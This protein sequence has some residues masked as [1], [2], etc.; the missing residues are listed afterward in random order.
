M[1]RKYSPPP[2]S[3][4]SDEK[5][6]P[7]PGKTLK[8]AV[9]IVLATGEE[10]YGHLT[11]SSHQTIDDLF[12]GPGAFLSLDIGEGSTVLLNKAQIQSAEV[13]RVPERNQL[14]RR[15]SQIGNFNA[16][17]SLNLEPGATGAAIKTAYHAM[18]RRYHPDRFSGKDVPPEILTYANAMLQRINLAYKLLSPSTPT[19]K[20]P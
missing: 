1:F 5:V 7:F 3:N 2:L 12:N 18:A 20:S 9:C 10:R 11:L 8:T 17:E 16:H 13:L 4:L 14:E 15:L 19:T 6:T